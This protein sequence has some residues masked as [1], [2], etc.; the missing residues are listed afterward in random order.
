MKPKRKQ[1]L[2]VRP[3][4]QENLIKNTS[5]DQKSSLGAVSFSAL[6]LL[7]DFMCSDKDVRCFVFYGFLFEY[8]ISVFDYVAQELV[9]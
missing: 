5:D 7:A 2:P 9:T 8:S 6:G 3:Q 1:N 4:K